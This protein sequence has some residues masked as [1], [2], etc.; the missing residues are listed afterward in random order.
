MSFSVLTFILFPKILRKLNSIPASLVNDK[1]NDFKKIYEGASYGIIFLIIPLLPLF[2]HYFPEYLSAYP[3]IV[4]LLLAQAILA[5]SF[6]HSMY[7][8]AKGSE[9]VL[10][11]I[12][13]LT[14]LL[15]CLFGLLFVQFYNSVS[16]I[17]IGT[18][19]SVFF[20]SWM[21]ISRA[22][23]KNTTLSKF[24]STFCCF[25]VRYDTPLILLLVAT[26][27][28]VPAYLVVIPSI[29]YFILNYNT[30]FLIAKKA[31]FLFSDFRL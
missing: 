12:A 22:A 1:L 27:Y 4:Y 3:T 29:I 28:A 25:S 17:A 18:I 30:M 19:L 8:M 7:L 14:V 10:G 31:Q 20:Y 2:L 15:N 13:F 5:K 9:R 24:R 11:S 16:I 6:F 21:T 26:W 23:L